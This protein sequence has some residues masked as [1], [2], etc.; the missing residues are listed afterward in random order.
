MDGKESLDLRFFS[1]RGN[2]FGSVLTGY[3]FVFLH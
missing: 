1:N 2:Q 3:A